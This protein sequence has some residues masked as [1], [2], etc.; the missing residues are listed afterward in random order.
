MYC[1]P[2]VSSYVAGRMGCET[3]RTRV[4]QAAFVNPPAVIAQSVVFRSDGYSV[5]AVPLHIKIAAAVSQVEPV[6]Q[7]LASGVK[8][9]RDVF[10]IHFYI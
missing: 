7:S 5:M 6:Y 8:A 4:Q 1:V 9:V 3:Y 2:Y 10:H